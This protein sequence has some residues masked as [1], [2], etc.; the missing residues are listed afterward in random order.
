MKRLHLICNAHLDPYWQWE[1]EEGAAEAI[2]TFRAAADLCDEFD[3][4]VFNHN[5]V[6]LYRWVEEYEPALFSR[7]QHLVKQGKWHIMGGWYLQPDC[8]MPSGESFV[9]QILL[10]KAYFREKFGVEPTTAI[11]LDPFGHT[12]GLAQ[13]LRK[14]GYD[15]YLFCRPN[16]EDCA[17]PSDDFIWVGY[18]GSEITGH[19]A[20]MFY[21]CRLGKAR[22]KVEGWIAANPDKP[23][24][25]VLWG[26]GNHGGGPSREDLRQLG[27]LMASSTDREIIHSTPETY[28]R[29][30]AASGTP[31]PRHAADIN[32][33]GVGC[34]TSMVRVKQKHRLLENEIL[35]AEKM[36]STAALQGLMTYPAADIR[37]ALCDLM[38]AEFHDILP[39]S[40][41]Q[42]VEEAALRLLDHGLETV[43]RVK[44]RAFFALCSG[45]PQAAEGQAPIVVFN[46]HPF[47]V[48]GI[49]SC[50]FQLADFNFADEFT[51]PIVHQHGQPVPCQVE[52]EHGNLNLDWRKRAVFV[53]ELAPCQ[54]TRF[55]SAFEVKPER[56]KPA[57]KPD[58]GLIRFK[59]DD[60]EMI[61]NCATGLVDKFAVNGIDVLKP[62]AFQ[63]LV[64]K[65]DEDPWSTVARSYREQVG[66]FTLLTQ[67][68]SARFS[69]VRQEALRPARVIEDGAVRTVVEVV[70]GYG[71]SF[72][73]QTYRMPKRGA[74]VE[75]EVRVHWNEKSNMLKWSIPTVFSHA[76]YIGQQAFGVEPLPTTGREVAAQKWVAAASDAAGMAFT[77]INDGVY[78]SDFA[79]GEL[80]VSL[81]RSPAYCGYPVGDRPIVMQDRYTPRIDQGERLYRFWVNAGPMGQRLEQVDREATV[82][83]EK[84]FALSFFPSGKGVRPVAGIILRDDVVQLAAFKKSEDSEE[85]IVRLFEPTGK[86][87]TTTLVMPP[88]DIEKQIGL[89]AF[90]VKTFRINADTGSVVETDLLERPLRDG[91]VRD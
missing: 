49:F 66:T 52:K 5:E 56:P 72:I 47:P 11:N 74:E 42:P 6:I 26:V 79:D 29:E 22:E 67:E 25:M 62:S 68:K 16:Q 65:D 10:G 53:A 13:I 35:T 69:G 50:E 20:S 24:G 77:C 73:C 12:R 41:I 40:S 60:M 89:G 44:G 81:L 88:L 85:F 51:V 9:R 70:M 2:S 45:Q 57:A 14:A 34:Y 80:R 48:R 28:F 19:R 8:N 71:N 91:G 4:F 36:A 32:P 75:I 86:A 27:A 15:S 37:E 58:N 18:D 90:E 17:L 59:T 63:P 30:L 33:W 38:T 54:V 61:I 46:P 3:G 82:H 1:W 7:I 21:N 83:N 43:S 78:G 76:R 64:M 39:G 23:T 84:A 87:R 31:L 55:D